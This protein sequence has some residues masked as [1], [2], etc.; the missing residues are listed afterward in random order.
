ME[1]WEPLLWSTPLHHS[2]VYHALSQLTSPRDEPLSTMGGAIE[3]LSPPSSP[4]PG[5]HSFVA[6]TRYRP[7]LTTLGWILLYAATFLFY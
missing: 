5:R 6:R 3:L 7:S 2:L 1:P 4:I